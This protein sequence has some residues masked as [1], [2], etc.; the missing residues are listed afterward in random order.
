LQARANLET[1]RFLLTKTKGTGGKWKRGSLARNYQRYISGALGEGPK[2]NL[3]NAQQAYNSQIDSFADTIGGAS[4]DLEI[5]Y[6][7]KYK[8][9]IFQEGE[10]G[11]E[12][13]R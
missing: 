4:A 6:G 12:P 5:A 9:K 1:L 3:L 10:V 7:K 2:G 13:V 11:L 8:I